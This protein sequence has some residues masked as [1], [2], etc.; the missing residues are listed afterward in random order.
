MNTLN[1]IKTWQSN[2]SL[3]LSLPAVL[4]SLLL[5]SQSADSSIR[6]DPLPYLKAGPKAELN[7]AGWAT[8]HHSR[9]ISSFATDAAQTQLHPWRDTPATIK[10]FGTTQTALPG[11][12]DRA[13]AAAQRPT[14]FRSVL[15]HYE[16]KGDL[17]PDY[18]TPMFGFDSVGFPNIITAKRAAKDQYKPYQELLKTVT[19]ANGQTRVVPNIRCHGY[20]VATTA[21]KAAKFEK[22]IDRYASRYSIN[23]DLVK[24][25]VTKESCFRTD[26][27]SHVGATGLMQLMPE[28]AEWLGV[29]D[30]NDAS[31]NLR[32]GVR[33]LAQL[34][35]RFGSDELALAAYNA[36]PGNVERYNGIPP[37]AETQGYVKAVMSYSLRYAASRNFNTPS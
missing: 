5:L 15:A 19:A 2:H 27:K 18:A 32:T 1:R 30:I 17:T 7:D 22:A 23:P 34:K 21:R 6:L 31:E 36:G 11:L 13:Y 35:R 28:T 10:S 25:V 8:T 9:I 20:S 12:G 24:A 16:S 26:A 33:Y 3:N 4:G 37:F 14:D 29:K